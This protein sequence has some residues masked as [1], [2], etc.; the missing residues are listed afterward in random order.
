MALTKDKLASLVVFAIVALLSVFYLRPVA[1]LGV[2]V[3]VALV[4]ALLGMALIWFAEPLGEVAS[5]SRGVPHPPP[6]LLIEIFGWILLVG[7]PLVLVCIL[8]WSEISAV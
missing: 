3:F 8:R 5:F 2:G 4:V 1:M 6:P 7:Y